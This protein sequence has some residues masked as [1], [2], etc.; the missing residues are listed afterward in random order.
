MVRRPWHV[1]TLKHLGFMVLFMLFCTFGLHLVQGLLLPFVFW[2]LN[3]DCHNGIL[4]FC[5]NSGTL[6]FG[7]TCELWLTDPC[8]IPDTEDRPED[9]S[10][11]TALQFKFWKHLLST[12]WG[13]KFLKPK[14]FTFLSLYCSCF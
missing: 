3:I 1:W 5:E 6:L 12:V 14:Q 4:N 10:T 8:R 7:E 11:C 13:K 2:M 9:I